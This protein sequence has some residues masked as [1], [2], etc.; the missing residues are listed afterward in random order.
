MDRFEVEG[1]LEDTFIHEEE[2][3]LLVVP[4][5]RLPFSKASTQGVVDPD[6]L[7]CLKSKSKFKESSWNSP[8]PGCP[9]MT[10]AGAWNDGAAGFL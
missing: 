2:A 3:L 5:D 9:V 1:L 8:T 6:T 4:D 7:S 10:A